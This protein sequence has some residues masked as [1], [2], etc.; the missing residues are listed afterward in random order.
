MLTPVNILLQKPYFPYADFCTKRSCGIFNSKF[1]IQIIPFYTSVNSIKTCSTG[2]CSCL[3][4]AK[5]YCKI[6]CRKFKIDRA[7]SFRNLNL[8]R[9][10][11]S[12]TFN[13]EMVDNSKTDIKHHFRKLN[14]N[15]FQ[16]SLIPVVTQRIKHFNTSTSSQATAAFT[17]KHLD[18]QTNKN[19]HIYLMSI[20][21]LNTRAKILNS[22]NFKMYITLT[23]H[24]SE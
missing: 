14:Y 21:T 10:I 23:L 13:F 22:E 12:F 18:K 9:F 8:L 3:V 6:S 17:F 1:V 16:K 2:M 15:E 24:F 4:N 11:G 5:L 20:F 7:K 19:T